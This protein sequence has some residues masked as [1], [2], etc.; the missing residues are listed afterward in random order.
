M[1]AGP[2]SSRKAFINSLL[3]KTAMIS[4]NSCFAPW[5]FTASSNQCVIDREGMRMGN[6]VRNRSYRAAAFYK[7]D[8]G[9]HHFYGSPGE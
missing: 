7:S 3:T 5:A 2:I 9:K 4:S 8:E 1:S 6:C